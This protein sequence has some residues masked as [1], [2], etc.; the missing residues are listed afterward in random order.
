MEKAFLDGDPRYESGKNAIKKSAS[1]LEK[2]SNLNAIKDKISLIHRVQ[3]DKFWEDMS[4][5]TLEFV[6][7]ELRELMKLLPTK[8]IPIVFTDIEDE[9]GLIL[10]PE[11]IFL[12]TAPSNYIERVT[13]FVKKNS[14][15]LVINKL[16][17][18]LPITPSELD[19]LETFLFDGDERG[20]KEDFITA[21]GDTKPL[22][23]FIR[24]IVG[25]DRSAAYAAFSDFMDS[26]PLSANQQ[27]FVG[28]IIDHFVNE[29]V[30]NLD[31]LYGVPYTNIH[32]SGIDGVFSDLQATKIVSILKSVNGN[33]G[34]QAG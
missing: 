29:G 28:M 2:L 24:S 8:E 12:P 3:A 6:R 33:V 11:D 13:A 19:Q 5:P 14:N 16:K 27:K 15:H 20:T 9:L 10:E 26:G 30:I 23:S 25:L 34:L 22:G 17:K 7:Q 31:Q 1:R 18:N 4:I 21:T 32:M